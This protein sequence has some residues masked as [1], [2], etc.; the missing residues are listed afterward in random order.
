MTSNEF[1]AF[2]SEALPPLG[3]C[4]S[5]YRRRNVRR[6]IVR[7]MDA[8]GIHEFPRYLELVRR[9][10]GE[11]EALRS[12]LV[13]TISR[14]FRNA[15]VFR[16][17]S[18]EIL[19]ELAAGPGPV[20]AWSAG[21]AAGEEAYSIRIAWEEMPGDSPGLRLLATDIDA[22]SLERAAA[23]RYPESSVR[24]VPE[25]LRRKYFERQGESYRVRGAI[26][27][28]VS[29]RRMDLLRQGSPGRFRLILCRN[30]AFTYF[31]PQQRL[32]VA[33]MLGASLADGGYLVIGRTEKLPADAAG[34]FEPAF[35]A[36]KIYRLRRRPRAGTVEPA[37]PDLGHKS[38]IG[39][40]VARGFRQ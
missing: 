15:D 36:E 1:D 12:L 20:A 18:R 7:R 22:V 3:L 40:P 27:R 33:A 31:G 19:P 4:P 29:F 5:A 8:A 11:R 13:V 23:G 38:R 2:L 39:Q 25:A 35:P 16:V 26:R 14:F 30:A 28:A 17:L 21:C 6:R 37:D 24:E 34:L 9:D 32:S 10:A